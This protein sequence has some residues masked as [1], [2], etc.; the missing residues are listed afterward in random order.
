[1]AAAAHLPEVA[2]ADERAWAAH[3]AINGTFQAISKDD[4][5]ALR[6]HLPRIERLY[7][8]L[9]SEAR[10]KHVAYFLYRHYE[11]TDPAR[12]ARYRAEAGD[13]HGN[14]WN[15]SGIYAAPRKKSAGE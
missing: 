13:D 14:P 5:E 9:P 6:Q 2:D 1:M 11:R 3:H 15:F 8:T 12:A 7:A 4:G 10:S